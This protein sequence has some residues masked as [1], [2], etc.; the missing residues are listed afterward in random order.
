[1]PD[2]WNLLNRQAVTSPAFTA[3]QAALS[4]IAETEIAASATPTA[5]SAAAH[6]AVSMVQ[7]ALNRRKSA[8]A[9]L[10][11]GDGNDG[12]GDI[13][14]AHF[15]GSKAADRTE[16]ERDESFAARQ[17]SRARIIYRSQQSNSGDL[18]NVQVT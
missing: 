8:A 12:S 15:D 17:V 2:I 4:A 13:S 16:S 18:T 10:G 9:E 1:M 3:V 5:S 14:G 11:G 7:A 6:E